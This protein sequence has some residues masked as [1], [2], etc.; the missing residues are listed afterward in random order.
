[1]PSLASDFGFVKRFDLLLVVFAHLLHLIQ[2]QGRNQERIVVKA[3]RGVSMTLEDGDRV[4]IIGHNGSGKSTLLKILAGRIESDSGSISMRRNTR[5]G[6]V[7]Q[8]ATFP[9]DQTASEVIAE[10]IVD[11]HLD[12]LERAAR[13][14]QT[15]G[16]AGF[17]DG[18]VRTPLDL[19]D[20]GFVLPLD[21]ND[22]ARAGRRLTGS[23][24]VRHQPGASGTSP[25]REVTVDVS[26]DD[27]KSWRRAVA[28]AAGDDRWTLVIPA[29]GRPGGH[30]TLR[31]NAVDRAGDRV[32]QTV[33]R[34][35][36]LR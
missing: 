30:V 10:A 29:G 5:V 35:Y 25:V 18:A 28:R 32:R 33:T 34:A 19:L 22:T 24:T 27:G 16:R 1:M 23:V 14:N 17:T 15:L 13:I 20:L 26:Y 8:Q 11:E 7:A 36:G 21:R 31:A 3:L 4:G 12:E 2:R 9:K 6:Y